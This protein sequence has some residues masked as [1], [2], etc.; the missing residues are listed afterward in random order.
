M[1]QLVLKGGSAVQLVY[2]IGSRSSLDIDLSL[3]TDFENLA[4]VDARFQAA[5]ERVFKDAG[6][7]V[8]DYSFQLRPTRQ[9]SADRRWGGYE[10]AFK[11]SPKLDFPADISKARREAI[12]IGP[13]QER[14]FRIQ[15]SRYEFCGDPTAMELGGQTV[16]VYTPAMLAVEKLRAICQQLPEYGPRRHPTPRARDFY[17]IPTI[18]TAASVRLGSPTNME[19]IR[20]C[21]AAKEVPLKLLTLVQESREFHRPDWP[22]VVAAAE[23]LS[24]DDFDRYFDSLV[25]EIETLKVLWIE[26]PP[27]RVE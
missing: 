27:S 17:D 19:L 26:D 23:N 10:V 7:V 14:I 18:C 21:F 24:L 11:V 9:V 13:S 5:L 12:V 25:R 8:F 4:D 1:S 15:M 16:V 20:Q 3:E 2:G 22:S 6:L